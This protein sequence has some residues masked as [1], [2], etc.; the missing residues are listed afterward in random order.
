LVQLEEEMAPA[1]AEYVPAG[2]SVHAEG[3]DDPDAP[4]YVPALHVRHVDGE[5]AP[6]V[7][8]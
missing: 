2:Q 5:K 1:N 6:V 7:V 3:D 4:L 8:E